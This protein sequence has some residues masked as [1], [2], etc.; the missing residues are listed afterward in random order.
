MIEELIKY[1][2]LDNSVFILVSL[3]GM[4]GHAIKKFVMGQLSGSLA[5]YIFDHNKKRTILAVLTP[6]GPP[7]A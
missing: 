6:F 4:L 1:A 5:N 3:F 7:V 2:T